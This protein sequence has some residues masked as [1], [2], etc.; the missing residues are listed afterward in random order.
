MLDMAGMEEFPSLQAE[1]AATL[2]EFVAFQHSVASTSFCCQEAFDR[3]RQLL[4][5]DKQDV[6]YPTGQLLSQ[7][8]KMSTAGA[9]ITDDSFA[10]LVMGKICSKESSLLVKREFT[11]VA[12]TIAQQHADLLS[13]RAKEII[14]AA[15][16]ESA[17]ND[18][19]QSKLGPELQ[20][21]AMAFAGSVD[22]G[23]IF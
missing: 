21:S 5:S 8:A 23:T 3:I 14:T 10:Q 18:Q 16:G 7:L 15:L 19:S 6:A 11:Q 22:S 2:A 4:Q 9:F 12:K 1:A 13:S 20:N 17:V